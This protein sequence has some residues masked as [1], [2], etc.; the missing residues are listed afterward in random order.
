MEKQKRRG[1]EL[2]EGL[3]RELKS[4]LES[5]HNIINRSADPTLIIDREGVVRFAN[6]ATADLFCRDS[7][8]MVGQLFGFPV[9]LGERTEIEVLCRGRPPAVVEMRVVET[10]WNGENVWLATLRD[11]T[12]RKDLER[13]LQ[14]ALDRSEAARSEIDAILRSVAEGLIVTDRD[15]RVLL[16]NHSSEL[17]LG[18]PCRQVVGLPIERVFWEEGA[19]SRVLE[20]LG[21]ESGECFDL[22]LRR[23]PREGLCTFQTRIS[24]IGDRE[25]KKGGAII[26]LQDVTR[27][28]EIER[29]KSEFVSIAAHD[30]RTPLTSIIGFADLLLNV[31]NLEIEKQR[32]LAR[33]IREQAFSMTDLVDSFLDITR[34]ESGEGIPLKKTFSSVEDLVR[35]LD[36]FIQMN[37]D[38]FS[39]R[40]DLDQK[41][42][43]LLI[44]C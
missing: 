40:I 23:Q 37:S 21:R 12:G 2:V 35:Q 19:R 31:E 18:L 9:L 1:E 15:N 20:A 4:C 27:A 29:M 42:T 17:M 11:V 33:I 25:G 26:T 3:K 30:L 24:V 32:E 38:K 8:E 10:E 36:P 43:G 13:E 28:R 39:F 7:E 44:D 22:E 14:E 34:I 5:F 16:M 6:P 41:G